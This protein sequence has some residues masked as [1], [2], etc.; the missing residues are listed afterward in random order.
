MGMPIGKM[1]I[2]RASDYLLLPLTGSDL[3]RGGKSLVQPQRVSVTVH[4]FICRSSGCRYPRPHLRYRQL[5]HLFICAHA[6]LFICSSARAAGWPSVHL[7]VGHLCAVTD[8]CAVDVLC[9]RDAVLHCIACIALYCMYW[10]QHE[11]PCLACA[12]MHA[13]GTCHNGNPITCMHCMHCCMMQ[14]LLTAQPQHDAVT[15]HSHDPCVH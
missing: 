9:S 3:V 5:S 12:G 1:S 10:V 15:A 14:Q 7:R 11:P 2:L 4:L 13:C 6:W 8:G